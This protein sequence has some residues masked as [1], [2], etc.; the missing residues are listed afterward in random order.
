V[1]IGHGFACFFAVHELIED[2]RSILPGE[3]LAEPYG[4]D[5]RVSCIEFHWHFL[6]Y[7]IL[8]RRTLWQLAAQLRDPLALIPQ[9]NFRAAQ[10]FSFRKIFLRFVRQIRLSKRAV[11]HLSCHAHLLW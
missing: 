11:D 8:D 1:H 5:G 6:E 7:V 4:L 3:K 10:L 9:F 2:D